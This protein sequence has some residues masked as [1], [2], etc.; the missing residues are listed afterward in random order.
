MKYADGEPVQGEFSYINGVGMLLCLV[1]N[2]CPDTACA[3]NYCAWYMFCPYH[4]HEVALSRI[5]RYLKATRGKGLIFNPPKKRRINSY[6]D[7]DF[8]RLYSHEKVTNPVCARSRTGFVISVVNCPFLWTS[9]LQTETTESTTE[10]E[11]IAIVYS[12][13]E[14]FPIMDIIQELGNAVRFDMKDL[15]VMHV[16]IHKDKNTGALVL[17]E[18]IP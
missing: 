14:L 2:T 3:V 15:T 7:T 12:C 13:L 8:T 5:G 11:I 17:T 16:S 18:K 1:G 9:K 6:P 4:S 10:A